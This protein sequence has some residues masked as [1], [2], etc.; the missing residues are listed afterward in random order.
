MAAPKVTLT[1]NERD[2]MAHATA[3]DLGPRRRLYRNHYCA[4]EGHHSWAELQALCERGLMRVL[5]KP[6][7]LSG[8][9]TV[10]CVTDAGLAALK[11][12]RP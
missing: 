6:S 7:A 1:V 4:S 10:F 5:R 11:G 9:D 12:T 8:G 2:V 3:W